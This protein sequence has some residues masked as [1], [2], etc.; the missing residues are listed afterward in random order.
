MLRVLKFRR[1][2]SRSSGLGPSSKCSDLQIWNTKLCVSSESSPEHW[3]VPVILMPTCTPQTPLHSH[4]AANTCPSS[5]E[6]G[7]GR[8]SVARLRGI[9]DLPWP[10]RAIAL[11][12][13]THSRSPCIVSGMMPCHMCPEANRIKAW[14]GKSPKPSEAPTADAAVSSRYAATL[15]MAVGCSGCHDRVQ[16]TAPFQIRRSSA[17]VH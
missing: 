1:R 3:K 2:T 9:A 16:N 15:Q 13:A 4:C 17:E 6:Q 8:G 11:H 7:V 5:E 14:Q 12:T 10:A